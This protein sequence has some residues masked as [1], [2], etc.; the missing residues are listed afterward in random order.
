MSRDDAAEPFAIDS[1]ADAAFRAEVRDWLADNAPREL[2][3]RAWRVPPD[4][5]QPWHRTLY[6]RGWIAPHW[7]TEHGVMESRSRKSA[8]LLRVA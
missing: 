5:L 2:C 4:E 8:N 3:V 1:A 6:E 7:P